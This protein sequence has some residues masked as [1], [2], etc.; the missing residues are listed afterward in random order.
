VGPRWTAQALLSTWTLE[1]GGKKMQRTNGPPSLN[2]S[3]A[4]SRPDGQ[5]PLTA[6]TLSPTS[7]SSPQSPGSVPTSPMLR[8]FSMGRNKAGKD[9]V[10]I[11]ASKQADTN[12][13]TS[14]TISAIPHYPESS[15][16]GSPK[17]G[18]DPSKSFFSNLMASK[19]SHRLQSP[20]RNGTGV[21][22]RATSKSRASS[23]DRTLY[24]LRNRGST[25][26]LPKTIRIPEKAAVVAAE[27]HEPDNL[28]Q[29]AAGDETV[30]PLAN[31]RPKPRFGGILSR[32]KSIRL[33]DGPKPQ[34]LTPDPTN[35]QAPAGQPPDR[36]PQ[37]GTALKS[38][39]LRPDHREGAFKE[40][41][42]SSI[43]NRSAD[44]PPMPSQESL[45]TSARKDKLVVVG[46]NLSKDSA[47]GH[48]LSNIHQTGRGMGDRLGKAGKGFLGKIT[49]SGSSNER[50]LVTDDT[51]TCTVINLPLIKQTRRT[52]IAKRLEFS[53]DKTEFWMPALPWRCIE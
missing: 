46:S 5:Q 52:R 36:D 53:R 51:Y 35:L 44:R 34:S 45:P 7:P 13:P 48:L 38:A 10:K 43:R 40:S 47:G 3:A 33:D 2:L 29:K 25:P 23:K 22:E 14:P 26:D 24:S 50:E 27:S 30:Q 6:S 11:E 18:R 9:K 4:K 8:D 28:S 20:D 12:G 41:T 21:S 39:P 49:R 32:T 31:R 1:R 42:G 16:P 37:Y 19:S 15:P 17:Y